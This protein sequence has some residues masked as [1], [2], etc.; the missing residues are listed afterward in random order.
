MNR[1]RAKEKFFKYLFAFT[2]VMCIIA[3]IAIFVFLIAE[4][5][6]AFKK[7]GFFNFVFGN[8]WT[9]DSSDTYGG[10]LH[11]RYG[12][13]K[14]IIGT[15]VA[16]VGSVTFGGVLGFF[17]NEYRRRSA[18]LLRRREG[19]RR[20]SRASGVRRG[21]PRCQIGNNRFDSLGYR[22]GGR[23]ND[24]CYNGCGQ[25]RKLSRGTV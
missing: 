13:F 18:K 10:E 21:S 20:N 23:R 1:A 2:A 4:S 22:Q 5:I 7:I 11:G 15:L 16:T 12:V 3:V 9:P 19:A 6:P 8:K 17:Q 14:M 24:G 25:L